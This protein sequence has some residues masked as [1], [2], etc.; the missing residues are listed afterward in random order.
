MVGRGIAPM[1]REAILGKNP[2]KLVHDPVTGHLGQDT[3]GGDAEAQSIPSHQGGLFH[4]QSLDGQT[5]DQGVGRGMSLLLQS[6]QGPPHGEMGR[7]ED[8]EMSD[9]LRTCLGDCIAHFG[10]LRQPE[11]KLL[12]LLVIELLGVI[13]TLEGKTLRKD[14]GRGN[15]R[16]RQGAP[17]R[18]INPSHG[19][20]PPGMKLSFV[21]KRRAP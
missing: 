17:P 15:N 21:K 7:P 10:I 2:I 4:G 14:H 8:V 16:S 5:V 3:G 9:F 20:D 11:V 19:V 13:Q 1:A 12:P 6:L 18:L